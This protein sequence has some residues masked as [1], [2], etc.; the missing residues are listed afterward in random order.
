MV[1]VRK[2]IQRN[3][4]GKNLDMMDA[5]MSNESKGVASKHSHFI[6]SRWFTPIIYLLGQVK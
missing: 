5:G 2:D 1:R 3:S 6:T 4:T